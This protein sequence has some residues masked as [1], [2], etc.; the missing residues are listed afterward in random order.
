VTVPFGFAFDFT[1][2]VFTNERMEAIRSRIGPSRQ[3]RAKTMK[4]SPCMR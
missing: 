3:L 4:Y 2:T 1:A